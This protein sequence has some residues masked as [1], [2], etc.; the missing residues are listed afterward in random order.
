MIK[1]VSLLLIVIFFTGCAVNKSIS[2][3]PNFIAE[4][5]FLFGQAAMQQND[6]DSAI[7]LFKKAVE[8]DSN[9][10]YLKEVLMETLVFSTY[11]NKTT[12]SEIIELGEKFLKQNIKSEKIYTFLANSYFYED[13]YNKAEKYYK[14]AIKLKPTMENLAAYYVYQKKAS[15]PG[16]IKLLNKAL[17]QPWNNEKLVYNIAGLYSEIDSLKSVDIYADAYKK[18]KNEE[19]LT[20]LLTAFEKIGSYDKVLEMIQLHLD[21]DRALSAPIKTYL[22]GRYFTLEM[23]DEVLKNKSICFDVGSHDILKYLFFSAIHKKDFNTGI[24]AGIAIEKSGELAEEFAP[25]F[26]TYFADLYLSSDN[27]AMAA[28]YL[29]KA[30]DL[31]IIYGYIFSDTFIGNSEREKKIKKL[32]LHYARS[33]KDKTK[34]NYLF[35][36]LLTELNEPENAL[37][38]LNKI[39][40]EFINENELNLPMAIA[41]LQNS[42]DIPRSKSL[43]EDYEGFEG[44]ANE[45]IASILM[46]T[47]HDST[48]YY[49][50]TEE[51][52]NNPKPDISTFKNCA[53]I[54][55]LYDEPSN[56][57]KLLTKGISI[58]PEDAELLNAAGYLIADNEIKSEYDT[59]TEYLKKAVSLMPESEMIWDSLAW[60]YFKQKKYN[61]ALVAMKV[62]LSKEINNS[63]IA[64]HIGAISHSLNEKKKAKYYFKLA[65]E[66][67]NDKKS[68]HLSKK[69]L[70]EY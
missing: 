67:N 30:E 21:N 14:K 8:S 18:W 40:D 22:I 48:A 42:L 1:V 57:L 61:E 54:G 50:L 66:L 41:Y 56:L 16:N 64:F 45:L 10:V 12:N 43:L 28:E 68:V 53:I 27:Y 39:S 6:F 35:G 32:L 20:K 26:Y 52:S 25:S 46:G 69:I 33:L 51:I 58:Y 37:E 59:A 5:Y 19:S 49:I 60:L 4:N 38:Y 31:E 15:P 17:K 36:I 62:P 29:K 13:Q 2:A 7:H 24:R 63:E 11:F 3:T 65:I 55:V 47:E 44:T 23:Y 9:N 70:S 34:A